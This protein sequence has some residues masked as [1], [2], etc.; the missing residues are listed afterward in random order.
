[1]LKTSE[2]QP[3]GQPRKHELDRPFACHTCPLFVCCRCLP[4]AF[5]TPALGSTEDTRERA[6]L[7]RQYYSFLRAGKQ[8]AD[9]GAA[10][11]AAGH[12]GCSVG[13]AHAG[14]KLVNKSIKRS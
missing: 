8:R 7:Q 3:G 11:G 2:E 4:A 12:A 1:M 14:E 9:R 5:M 10:E 13:C 6:E